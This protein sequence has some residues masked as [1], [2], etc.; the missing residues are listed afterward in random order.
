MRI[1]YV[2]EKYTK[3]LEEKFK[4]VTS[5]ENFSFSKQ[6]DCI[7]IIFEPMS[8]IAVSALVML[9]EALLQSTYPKDVLIIDNELITKDFILREK[10]PIPQA[11]GEIFFIKDNKIYYSIDDLKTNLS[12]Q[13]TEIERIKKVIN[14]LT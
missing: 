11:K 7:I 13:N 4:V 5:L 12:T 1:N 9:K 10:I 14:Q 3:P 2:I 8:S 6:K